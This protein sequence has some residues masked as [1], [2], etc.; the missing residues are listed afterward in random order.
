MILISKGNIVHQQRQPPSARSYLAV[1]VLFTPPMSY[2][3]RNPNHAFKISK[4]S[5][6]RQHLRSYMYRQYLGAA[7]I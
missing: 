1:C 2:F 5:T 4:P 7:K 3:I 6:I